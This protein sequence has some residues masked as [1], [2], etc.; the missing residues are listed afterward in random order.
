LTPEFEATKKVR[1]PI[2]RHIGLP[3]EGLDAVRC[4]RYPKLAT[5]HPLR[6]LR[7]VAE[8]LGRCNAQL[9]AN[10][11]VTEVKEHDGVVTVGTADGATVSAGQAVVATN[12][13][14][15]DRF[16]LHTQLA[17]YRTYAMAITIDRDSIEPSQKTGGSTAATKASAIRNRNC[18]CASTVAKNSSSGASTARRR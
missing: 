1:M 4:L 9:F 12:S 15:N 3:F 14:I 6:Y 13:P 17:P 8:A 2:E 16:A 5:F 11:I 18:R 10:T 7:G